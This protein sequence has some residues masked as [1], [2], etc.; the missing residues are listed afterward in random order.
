MAKIK[1]DDKK[2]F[3][4]YVDYQKD[5]EQ[6]TGDECKEL[7]MMIF[8][9][10]RTH[11]EPLITDRFMK[12]AWGR[13]QR[14]LDRNDSA[15]LETKQALSE[16][17]KRGAEKRWHSQNSHPI[18]PNG[19]PNSLIGS[20][21][22]NVNDNVNANVFR[23]TSLNETRS[24]ADAEVSDEEFN[25]SLDILEQGYKLLKEKEDRRY[26]SIEEAANLAWN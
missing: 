6:L 12:M 3:I 10:E 20:M 1:T 9:Y 14:D 21:A 26:K 7:M 24:S 17:G 5:F 19:H 18:T 8:N 16:A 11:E 23:A 15:W 13:I 22:V 2:S 4:M 25:E